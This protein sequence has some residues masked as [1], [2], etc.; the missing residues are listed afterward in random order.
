MSTINKQR[1]LV[2]EEAN[3]LHLCLRR[4]T[5]YNAIDSATLRDLRRTLDDYYDFNGSLVIQGSRGVFSLGGDLYELANMSETSA[6]EFSV[7][8]HQ[9]VERIESW[10]HPTVALVDGYAIGAGYELCL[11]CDMIW[12]SNESFVGLPGLAWSLMPCMGGLQRIMARSHFLMAQEAFLTGRMFDAQEA[13]NHALIDH[14]LNDDDNLDVLFES[15]AQFSTTAVSNIRS[16]RMEKQG[17][18]V[19]KLNAELFAEPFCSGETQE[20]L[21]QLIDH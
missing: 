18:I 7:L 20:R 21:H 14:I 16:L 15:F 4:P 2:H 5:R 11:A 19:A 10:P 3:A 8:A 1:I 9:C 13:Y 6:Y 12:A 17:I